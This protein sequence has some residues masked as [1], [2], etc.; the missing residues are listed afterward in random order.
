MND[1]QTQVLF[2]I[3]IKIKQQRKKK[4]DSEIVDKIS[5]LINAFELPAKAKKK[6]ARELKLLCLIQIWIEIPCGFP[7]FDFSRVSVTNFHS[8]LRLQF[9]IFFVIFPILLLFVVVAVVAFFW[10]EKSFKLF[11]MCAHC[12]L[13]SLVYFYFYFSFIIT[14]FFSP[15]ANKTSLERTVF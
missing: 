9:V 13:S 5:Y 3:S 14:I 8:A 12:K 2:S 10:F 4:R 11:V 1:P 15:C 7:S 6:E